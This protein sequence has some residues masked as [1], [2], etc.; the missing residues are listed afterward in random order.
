MSTLE[1]KIDVR[2]RVAQEQIAEQ[3]DFGIRHR[4]I[5]SADVAT[6]KKTIAKVVRALFQRK[7]LKPADEARLR[8]RW[9]GY[10]PPLPSCCGHLLS[11]HRGDGTCSRCDCGELC[12]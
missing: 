3:L 1:Y 8:Q 4:M 12:P 10:A 7:R 6:A 11:E 2:S 9:C 5:R